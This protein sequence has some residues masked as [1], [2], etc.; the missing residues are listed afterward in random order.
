MGLFR[1]N[2]SDVMFLP[3]T[4]LFGWFHGLI[5]LYALSTLKMVSLF[6]LLAIRVQ[7]LT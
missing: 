7:V 6:I 4:I 5:K 3:A 1:R 2:P